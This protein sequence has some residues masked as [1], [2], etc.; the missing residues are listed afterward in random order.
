ML[1]RMFVAVSVLVAVLFVFLTVCAPADNIGLIYTQAAND[2]SIGIHGD[3]ETPLG[4]HL[5]VSIEG[6][7]QSGDIYLGNLV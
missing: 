3:Y 1:A 4:D 5:D 6:Q 7:L 2:V